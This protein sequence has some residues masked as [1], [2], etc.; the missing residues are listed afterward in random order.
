MSSEVVRRTSRLL[1]Q[2]PAYNPFNSWD[3]FAF[4]VRGNE[5]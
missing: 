5:R 2:Y 1:V 4:G 3:Y